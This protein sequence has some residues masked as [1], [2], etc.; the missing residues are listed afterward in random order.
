MAKTTILA[1]FMVVLILGT[2]KESQGQEMCHDE[3]K[4]HGVC[5]NKPCKVQC[6]AMHRNGYGFCVKGRINCFCTYPCTS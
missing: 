4:V 2:V 1:I 3:I 5:E 6:K